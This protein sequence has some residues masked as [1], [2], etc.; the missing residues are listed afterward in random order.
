MHKIYIV[1]KND[2]TAEHIM[3]L[4]LFCTKYI[5]LVQMI[6]LL[7]AL[8]SLDVLNNFRRMYFV[9]VMIDRCNVL[10]YYIHKCNV[11]NYKLNVSHFVSQKIDKKLTESSYILTSLLVDDCQTKIQ[12]DVGKVSLE[13][14]NTICS[15]TSPSIHAHP[16]SI[17][18]P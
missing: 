18:A 17:H 7:N 13:Y 16:P 14:N 1:G 4:Y 11:L 10:I 9:R 8:W 2:L 3:I 6:W 12:Y 15:D 5:L